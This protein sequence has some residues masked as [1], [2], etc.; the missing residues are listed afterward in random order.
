MVE[1][2]E[3]LGEEVADQAKDPPKDPPATISA[4][5]I[6]PTDPSPPT[7]PTPPPRLSPEDWAKQKMQ[8]RI[9]R[10]TR[11]RATLEAALAA[12]QASGTAPSPTDDITA[13]VE[14]RAMAIVAQREFNTKCEQVVQLGR[15]TFTDFNESVKTLQ[16]LA[17]LR[18]NEDGTP[19]NVQ[20]AARYTSFIDAIIETGE[21]PRLIHDLASDPSEAERIFKMPPVKQG[22]A[23][24]K[25]AASEPEPVSNAPKPLTPIGN[26]AGTRVP[27]D[28]RDVSRADNLST[29]EWITRRNQQVAEDAKTRRGY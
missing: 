7:I 15:K 17:D 8:Q 29:A 24:A 25:L 2:T 14:S 21:G 22:V 26:R 4:D 3:V 23:L 9:D 11:E 5:P 20:E 10:L 13:Q 27:I 1:E 12:K 6:P 19:I 18:S 28:P 16:Q